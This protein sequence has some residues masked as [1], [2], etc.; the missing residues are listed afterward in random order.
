MRAI[1]VR[2]SVVAALVAA[3]AMGGLQLLGTSPVSGEGAAPVAA[4]LKR[5]TPQT[6]AYFNRP[7]GPEKQQYT[8]FRKLTRAIESTPGG[9]TIRIAAYSFALGSVA[10]ALLAAHR[11][12]VHVQL[13]FN[14]HELY[15]AQKRLRKALGSNAK[16]K[17]YVVRCQGSCRGIGGNMHQKFFM[18]S[19]V[20]KARNVVMNG[21]NNVT[22]HNAEDQ[23]ADLYVVVGKRKLYLTFLKMFRQMRL[24]HDVEPTYF[25]QQVQKHQAQFFPYRKVPRE[26][27]PLFQALAPIR[28]PVTTPEPEPG[29][30]EPE[31]IR[32][33]TLRISMFA[34]NGMRGRDL[35][36]RVSDIAT[37]GCRVEVILGEGIGSAVRDILKANPLVTVT[38]PTATNKRGTIYTHQKVFSVGGSY[39]SKDDA[40]LVW[41]GSHNWSD[42]ALRRDDLLLR[43][44]NPEIYARYQHSFDVIRALG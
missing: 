39:G 30:P 2:T 4:R 23:W 27:D 17:S 20:G 33:T 6:T 34:W 25:F 7:V 35:A 10:D 29:K 19:K 18:F 15:D 37:A 31:P 44:N 14:D 12:G 11:R 8:L 3:L 9:E 16:K 38:E 1:L 43:V 32:H 21:S 13:I 5:F 42:S 28:C 26:Q 41:T 36:L 24:D 40:T 22:K